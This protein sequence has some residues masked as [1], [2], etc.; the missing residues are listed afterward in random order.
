[1]MINEL[2]YEH[3][4]LVKFNADSVNTIISMVGEIYCFYDFL[5]Q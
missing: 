4:K 1:V 2:K 3:K 5:Y